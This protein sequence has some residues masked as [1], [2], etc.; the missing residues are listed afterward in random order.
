MPKGHSATVKTIFASTLF[1]LL[2]TLVQ[3]A[4]VSV[5]ATETNLVC[6]IDNLLIDGTAYDVTFGNTIDT[7]FAGNETGAID[8]INAIDSAI[9][10]DGESGIGDGNSTDDS[11]VC[12]SCGPEYYEVFDTVDFSMKAGNSTFGSSNEW[13]FCCGDPVA[14]TE[15]TGVSELFAEFTT[16]GTATP[17]PTTLATMLGGAALMVLVSRKRRTQHV[18]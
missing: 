5:C 9:N 13:S 4:S 1:L 11:F 15:N 16:P 10:G 17:E 3:A 6:S 2:P 12:H 14:L 18:R 8:A 7:T